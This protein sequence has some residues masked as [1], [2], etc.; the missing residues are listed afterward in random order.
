M[1][2]FGSPTRNSF[3]KY[4]ILRNSGVFY[5][6]DTI[7]DHS[8]AFKFKI[9]IHDDFIFILSNYHVTILEITGVYIC[10]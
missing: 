8:G 1:F 7:F 6:S 10:P 2:S 5:F 9:M 3:G 4:N